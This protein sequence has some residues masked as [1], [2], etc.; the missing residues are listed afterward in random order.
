MTTV[1]ISGIRIESPF[2]I[3]C[4][5]HCLPLPSTPLPLLPSTA[6]LF[7]WLGLRTFTKFTLYRVLFFGCGNCVLSQ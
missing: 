6:V 7:C 5:S 1:S 2:L 4:A 3:G